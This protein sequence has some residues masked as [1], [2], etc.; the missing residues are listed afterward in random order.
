VGLQAVS[1]T[2]WWTE[3]QGVVAKMNYETVTGQ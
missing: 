2:Q 1:T 3:W